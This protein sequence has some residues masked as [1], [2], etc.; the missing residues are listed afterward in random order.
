MQTNTTRTFGKKHLLIV[1]IVAL[2]G[3]VLVGEVTQVGAQSTPAT[4]S[5]CVRDGSASWRHPLRK[6][7]QNR[8]N[9]DRVVLNQVSELTGLTN[10]V[11]VGDL[12]DG[13]SLAEISEAAG[14]SR[15][16][17]IDGITA[18]VSDKIDERVASGNVAPE[19]KT[20]WMTK[21]AAN[22]DTIIDWHLGYRR[23]AAPS[24]A[25]PDA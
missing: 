23:D 6:L 4:T 9:C 14:I 10:D 18:A 12:R 19:Q 8:G 2:F 7:R 25:T 24:I 15:T 5:S 11:I 13:Q 3:F 20:I 17:L 22:I 16:E 1:A 21:L